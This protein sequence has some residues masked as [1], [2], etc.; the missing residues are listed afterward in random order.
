MRNDE[1]MMKRPEMYDA[2]CARGSVL[3]VHMIT[4]I[5]MFRLARGHCESGLWAACKSL[6][7]VGG[8]GAGGGWGGGGGLLS[9][10]PAVHTA[11]DFIV[12]F[13]LDS[14]TALK[15]MFAACTL[16]EF[17]CAYGNSAAVNLFF[18]CVQ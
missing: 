7:L 10:F 6:H 4:C 16:N 15:E 12:F 17:C 2:I 3:C 13:G 14:V 8:G 11:A 9:D 5:C 1:Q 18:L